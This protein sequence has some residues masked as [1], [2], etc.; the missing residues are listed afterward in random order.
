MKTKVL[1]AT[2]IIEKAVAEEVKKHPFCFVVHYPGE[3]MNWNEVTQITG[4]K[5][6]NDDPDNKIVIISA[7]DMGEM[8]SL[9]N[10]ILQ[11]EIQSITTAYKNGKQFSW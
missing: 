6:D 7:K 9:W 2:T 3:S 4:T 8:Q 10:K 5:S 1:D 11:Q